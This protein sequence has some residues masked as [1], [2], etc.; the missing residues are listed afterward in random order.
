MFDDLITFF[1]CEIIP[2]PTGGAHYRVTN[3]FQVADIQ[4][5]DAIAWWFFLGILDSGEELG[6]VW[7]YVGIGPNFKPFH[8]REDGCEYVDG[9]PMTPP[10]YDYSLVEG[11]S[12]EDLQ[13]DDLYPATRVSPRFIEGYKDWDSEDGIPF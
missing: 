1:I 8:F 3:D 13:R 2:Q 10:A 4:T 5:L 12:H 6:I 11:E 7:K 9:D